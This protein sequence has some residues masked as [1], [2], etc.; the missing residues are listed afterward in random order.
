MDIERTTL[1]GNWVRLEPL[2]RRHLDSL[3]AAI[4][5]GALWQIPVTFVPHPDEL[6]SFLDNADAAFAQQRELTFATVEQASNAV[7]GSTRFR[8]IERAHRRVEIGF[9]FVAASRQRTA[10]NTE[11]K[12]LML[13][14]AF[15]RWR[16]NRVELLTDVRNV[17]SRDAIARLGASEEGVLRSHMIM[18]DG[19]VRDS[20][21]FGITSDDWPL[22]KSGLSR[23]M[24]AYP[25]Q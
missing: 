19:H 22:L 2:E 16:C 1:Q 25:Q 21:V 5:D 4:R 7:V 15:E 3:A 12:Y 9:T 10:I 11:A 8:C 6:S 14:H 24:G 23:K 17:R 18:R 20:V 13:E